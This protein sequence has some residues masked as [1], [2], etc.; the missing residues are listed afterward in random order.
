MTAQTTSNHIVYMPSTVTTRDIAG[1]H[2]SRSRRSSGLGARILD[3]IRFVASTPRRH[4]IKTEL[5]RLSD[6]ELA[7]IGLTRSEISHVFSRAR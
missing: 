2:A 4:A 6:R 5:S 7:D 3:G 1:Q